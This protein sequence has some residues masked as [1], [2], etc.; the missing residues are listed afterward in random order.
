L[1][2]SRRAEGWPAVTANRRQHRASL[3]SWKAVVPVA[4]LSVTWLLLHDHH[5][6]ADGTS[7]TPNAKQ[8]AETAAR[9]LPNGPE[10]TTTPPATSLP[11]SAKTSPAS[12]EESSEALLDRYRSAVLNSAYGNAPIAEVL[13]ALNET[14]GGPDIQLIF[15]VLALRKAE[16]LPLVKDRLRTGEMFEKHALTKFLRNCPWPETKPELLALAGAKAEHWLPRQGALYALGALGDASAGPDVS[17]LLREP[18]CPPG[19]QLVAIATL[20]RIGYRDAASAVAS[21]A[22][23]DDIHVRL[24]ATRALAEFGEPVDQ[25]FMLAA[26]RSEDYLVRQEA[27]EA[28][29]AAGRADVTD[30]LHQVATNDANEAVRDSAAQALL[31]RELHALTPAAKLNVLQR[32]L[33]GATWRNSLWIVQTLVSQCGPEGRTFVTQLAHRDNPLGERSRAYLVL[34]TA[35]DR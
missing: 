33:D 32:A 3:R 18:D 31:R 25:E 19:V 23:S 22:K 35:N 1:H 4:V 12:P 5:P 6:A 30:R 21:F 11:S 9:H 27:C 7:H 20:A 13:R 10:D 26:L 8:S 24:F 15:Q 14:P 34:A 28:F 16:A 29:G 2:R 17:A